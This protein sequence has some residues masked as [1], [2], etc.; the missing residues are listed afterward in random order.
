MAVPPLLNLILA[1]SDYPNYLSWRMLYW[2]L[3]PFK[4]YFSLLNVIGYVSF[5]MVFAALTSLLLAYFLGPWFIRFLKKINLKEEIRDDGPSSH[6]PK[7]GTPTMGG[8]FIMA[9]TSVSYILWGNLSHLP[10]V[11]VW[12]IGLAL[13]FLGFMDD[14]TKTIKKDKKGVRPR[15]K[16]LF[17]FLAATLFSLGIYH[18][19]MGEHTTQLYLPFIKEPLLDLGIFSVFLWVLVVVSTSNA[20]NLTDG[21]DGLAIGLSIVVTTT[22]GIIAYLSGVKQ[23]ATHLL[24]PYIPEVNELSVYLSALTGAGIGFLWY[25]SHPAEMFMGDTGSLALGGIIGMSAILIKREFL[26]L[27]LGGIFVFEALSVIIQVAYFKSTKKR[28]FRMAPVHHHFELKGWHE[29]KVVTRFWIMGILLALIS[30]SS[31]KII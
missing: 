28:F 12:T 22:L 3:Y 11:L 20:V 10:G 24:I 18:L 25:N 9:I 1:F 27:I 31:L 16:L 23:I 2:G 5:R 21:L 6:F 15:V 29:N 14:Y 30:I 4:D 13:S 8:L 19:G 17:Q 26:L 7:A